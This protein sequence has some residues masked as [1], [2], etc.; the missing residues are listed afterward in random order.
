MQYGF[1]V[2]IA[3]K[4]TLINYLLNNTVQDLLG[5]GEVIVHEPFPIFILFI[6]SFR[7]NK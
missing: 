7:I 4:T 1:G 6:C 2:A 3:G 5:E